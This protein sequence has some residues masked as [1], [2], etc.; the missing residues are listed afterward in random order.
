MKAGFFLLE[1]EF[2]GSQ[3]EEVRMIH[4]VMDTVGYISMNYAQLNI[5]TDGYTEKSL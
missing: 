5:V 1:R 4:V 3:W 2:T